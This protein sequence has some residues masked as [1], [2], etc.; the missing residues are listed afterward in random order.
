MT[1]P[2]LLQESLSLLGTCL[3]VAE[4]VFH[5]DDGRIYDDSEIDRSQRKQIGALSKYYEQNDGEKQCEWNIYANDDGAAQIAEED[6]LDEE[7]QQAAEDQ[8][9]Q[10]RVRRHS[11]QRCAVVVRYNLDSGRQ[12]AVMVEPVNFCFDL[13]D[14]DIGLLGSPHDDNRPNNVVIVIA[15]QNAKPWPIADVDLAYILYQYWHAVTLVQDYVL[16]VGNVVALCQIITAPVID[17]SNATN[18]DGLLPYAN[19]A[20]ANIEVRISRRSYNLR[21][22][23]VVGFQFVGIGLDLEFLRG[24]APTVDRRNAGNRQ[25]PA[26]NHPVLHGTEIHESE[27]RRSDDLVAVDFSR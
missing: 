25:Q 7:N 5:E 27:M 22:R 12:A 19:F 24:T 3:K 11:D 13:G 15:A 14:H 26:C 2:K 1:V 18:I 10:H 4:D 16:N 6:P 9:V 8:V 21:H 20:S 17:Q 23:D